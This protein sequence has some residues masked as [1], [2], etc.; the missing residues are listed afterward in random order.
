GFTPGSGA[1]AERPVSAATISSKHAPSTT[2]APLPVFMSLS[3]RMR[4]FSWLAVYPPP[5][6]WPS[7]N[8]TVVDFSS[9]S[10]EK[11]PDRES[12]R[13]AWVTLEELTTFPL[14]GNELLELFRAVAEGMPVAPLSLLGREGD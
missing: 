6:S 13:A 14:R 9:T 10:F 7:T 2:H 11:P 4:F 1:G 5:R 3:S 8:L 12:L